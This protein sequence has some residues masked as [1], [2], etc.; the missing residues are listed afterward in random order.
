[1]NS[2]S[3]DTPATYEAVVAALY[4]SEPLD[5]WWIV[6]TRLL[7][8]MA[9]IRVV[10]GGPGA[11]SPA[12][13]EG[14]RADFVTADSAANF[15][16]AVWERY[17]AHI[18]AISG[19]IAPPPGFL[20]LALNAVEADPRIATVSFFSNDAGLL[21]F[22]YRNHADPV[23][24]AGHDE[25]SITRRLR[26][27][28]PPPTLANVP[29]AVGS[30]VL[31]SRTALGVID[32]LADA[33]SGGLAP[34]IADLSLTA[35]LRG[36]AALVDC[37]TYVLRPSDLNT[38]KWDVEPWVA[39]PPSDLAE[40]DEKWLYQR[41]YQASSFMALESAVEHSSLALGHNVARVKVQGLRILIDG[42]C[43]SSKEQ[44]SQVATLSMI[45]AL[46]RRDDVRELCVALPAE[47]G[48]YTR[49]AL[50]SP[51]IQTEIVTL[52]ELSVFGRV[53]IAHTPVIPGTGYYSVDQWRSVADRVVLTIQDLIAFDV[54]DYFRTLDGWLAYRECIRRSAQIVD[55]IVVISNDVAEIVSREHL[56]IESSRVFTVP[57][58][59]DHL[60]GTED[61]EIPSELIQ[62]GFDSVDFLL[63]LGTNYACR[64]R[65]IALATWKELR[66]RGLKHALVMAGGAVPFG[67]SRALEAEWMPSEGLFTL[68]EVTS[69][70]RNWL[71]RHSAL[72]LC[73]S[74]AEGF[75]LVPFEAARFGTPA[76]TV[77]YGPFR[78][79]SGEIPVSAADWRP[80]SLASAAQRLLD[81]HDLAI[82][83]TSTRL[84]A[85]SIY[86]WDST[87]EG[88]VTA[89]R[90]L[91]AT[92][93]RQIPEVAQLTV[94]LEMLKQ[95]YDELRLSRS[96]RA[97][98][99]VSNLYR[100]TTQRMSRS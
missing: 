54:G 86:T 8:R 45:E 42:N 55:G 1:M 11:R 47:V 81:D 3:S 35:R 98:Q 50:S 80:Q 7:T 88:L 10:L 60:T 94:E 85:G 78:E 73:T 2:S 19:G 87:A 14:L 72:V 82:R 100:T 84:R 21:S 30:V 63:C 37:G 95:R 77:N 20:D 44:G 6:T 96:F 4:A 5:D 31:V 51:K 29:L 24:M 65:D 89:Y 62:R 23:T 99:M 68:P 32:T 13:G 41:H 22:P 36:F 75:G 93:S 52:G 58:G 57:L 46:A 90:G 76:L 53:D 83:Q 26:S 67:T 12:T 66:R 16:N 15:L 79:L 39:P 69:V 61:E 38:R 28:T 17:G 71:L 59:T 18:L 40:E 48:L 33:P 9:Q 92:P 49:R 70:E 43:L 91:L 25:L 34:V 74:S 97:A 56:P 64:N 27:L